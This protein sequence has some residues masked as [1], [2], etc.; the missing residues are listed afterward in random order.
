MAS[1]DFEKLFWREADS[2]NLAAYDVG[3]QE[4]IAVD[5]KD[6]ES[7]DLEAHPEAE[8][9]PTRYSTGRGLSAACWTSCRTPGKAR[10]FSTRRSKRC[11]SGRAKRKSSLRV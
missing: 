7:F 10:A 8:S 6:A 4:T 9:C 2:F 5:I 11:A 3:K 1:I